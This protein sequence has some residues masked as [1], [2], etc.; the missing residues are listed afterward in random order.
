MSSPAQLVYQISILILSVNAQQFPTL[1]PTVQV[2]LL[3]T[4][5]LLAR[6]V[7]AAG[8]SLTQETVKVCPQLPTVPLEP[9]TAELL[10]VNNAYRLTI[11]P[12]QTLVLLYLDYLLI[13]PME[14]PPQEPLSAMRAYQA[15]IQ[16]VATFAF[17]FQAETTTVIL[18][19]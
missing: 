16:T 9:S 4:R 6:P 17:R 11:F 14:A 15:I 12:L 5:L 10:P 8:A 18:D 19:Q 3:P 1:I 7:P 2:E 13:V